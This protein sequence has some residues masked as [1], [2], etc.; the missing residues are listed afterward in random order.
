MPRQSP[1]LPGALPG[2][3]TSDR[4]NGGNG[5]R[6]AAG[7]AGYMCGRDRVTGGAS[8]KTGGAGAGGASRGVSGKGNRP[9]LAHS[10]FTRRPDSPRDFNGLPRALVMPA[11]LFEERQRALGAVRGPAEKDLVIPALELHRFTLA[12]RIRRL[13][14]APGAL[15]TIAMASK[16]DRFPE[17]PE[18][19]HAWPW[20]MI[21]HRD[22]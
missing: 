16:R 17:M 5:V 9:H 3:G 14:C 10:G 12:F 19:G 13:R 21:V 15:L 22:V 4:G 6:E 18:R 11:L 20:A 2:R 1:L 8:G 7:V